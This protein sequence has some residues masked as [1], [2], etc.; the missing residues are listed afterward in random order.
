MRV[1]SALTR[2]WR[3]LKRLACQSE[4]RVTAQVFT[5]YG[6]MT[7]DDWNLILAWVSPTCLLSTGMCLVFLDVR[8][9]ARWHRKKLHMWVLGS[10]AY[11]GTRS[12]VLKQ[13]GHCRW[14][15]QALSLP[16]RLLSVSTL[17]A[18]TRSLWATR[19]A[20]GLQVG[21]VQCWRWWAER[22][23]SA[24]WQCTATIRTARLWLIS[25]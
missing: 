17:W 7:F 12:A 25:W 11:I 9:K 15:N 5:V 2:W 23:R 21:W 16:G 8:M 24:P 4:G 1:C 14:Y 3:Q 19:L 18:A 20:L 10:V 22:C 13:C 6:R